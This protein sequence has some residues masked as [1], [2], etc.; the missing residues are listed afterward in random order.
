MQAQRKK[1][2][3]KMQKNRRRQVRA[4]A[5][6]QA[7]AAARNER[8]VILRI[9]FISSISLRVRPTGTA[10]ESYVL[11]ARLVQSRFILVKY[12]THF[13]VKQL[14]FALKRP[15]L[16]IVSN[17]SIDYFDA[18]FRFFLIFRQFCKFSIQPV[19]VF[20]QLRQERCGIVVAKNT[21]PARA[22]PASGAP[23]PG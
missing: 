23:A 12:I 11:Y 2:L 16:S 4:A 21:A 15:L 8:R 7:A 1:Q 20:L 22:C 19:Q 3:Q 9:M 17:A 6:P 13:T 5:A 10:P 18:L 14:T